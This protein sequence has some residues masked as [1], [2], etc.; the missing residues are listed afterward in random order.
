MAETFEQIG[1]GAY[2]KVY[3]TIKNSNTIAI[4]RIQTSPTHGFPFTTIREIKILKKFIHPNIVKLHQVYIKDSDMFLEM[5]YL[6]YDLS[7]LIQSGYKFTKTQILSFTYQ[8]LQATSYIHKKG[9]VHR[10]IKSSNILI[11]KNGSLKLADFGLTK[12]VGLN[13]TNRVCTLYY[14]APELLLGSDNYNVTVDSFSI[15]CVIIEMGSGN[16][17]FKG[18]D[19]IDQVYLIFKMLGVPSEKYK[20]GHL[21]DYEKFVKNESF[22]D[23]IENLY[24][25]YFEKDILILLTELLRLEPKQRLE[26]VNG[27]KFFCMKNYDGRKE[28]IT[29][30]DL[31]EMAVKEKKKKNDDSIFN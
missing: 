9:M 19:E 16:I 3:K 13:M 6:P 20:W 8:L 27:L 10:D 1:E 21:F 25:K 31:H 7:A 28:E 24:G 15:A 14:R 4:K 12:K 23:V 17:A 11:A 2:G 26:P 29:I 30:D 22:E 18:S 5:E